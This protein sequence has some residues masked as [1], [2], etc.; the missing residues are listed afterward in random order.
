VGASN[1]ARCQERRP[2]STD[3]AR[4]ARTGQ[5]IAIAVEWLREARSLLRHP[6]A[7]RAASAT[8]KAISSAEGAARHV[9]HRIRRIYE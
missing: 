8:G 4:H 1:L 7:R 3:Y 9:C 2:Y 6:G 5:A